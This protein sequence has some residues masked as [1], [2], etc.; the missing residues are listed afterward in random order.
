VHPLTLGG[1]KSLRDR[2]IPV[3]RNR[4]FAAGGAALI[5]ALAGCASQ[6]PVGRDPPAVR[7]SDLRSVSFTPDLVKF[8]AKVLIENRNSPDMDFEKIDYAVDMFDKPLFSDTFN[9]MKRTRRGGSQTVTFPF[10]ISMD[11][12]RKQG[13][14]VLS[15][16]LLRVA[17]HSQVFTAASLGFDPVPFE[18]TVTIPVPQIPVVR[19]LGTA[20]APFSNAFRIRLGVT[21][22]NSF[23]F[24]VDSIDSYLVLNDTKYSLLRMDRPTEI[25]AGGAGSIVL[26]MKTTPTKVLSLALNLA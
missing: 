11:D 16:I 24:T 21:N 14:A 3:A 4:G 19:L 5:L 17:F 26:Q 8:Q 20:G 2:R 1:T 6:G 15:E 7:V 18:A 10:Q 22:P 13:L 23:P 9:G 25:A 12:I